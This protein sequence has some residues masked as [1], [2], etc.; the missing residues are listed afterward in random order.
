MNQD[1]VELYKAFLKLVEGNSK[2]WDQLCLE[3]S[4]SNWAIIGVIAI[5][6]ISIII[7]A[8]IIARLNKKE[9]DYPEITSMCIV[10]PLIITLFLLSI[11]GKLV[12]DAVSPS[13]QLTK[14]LLK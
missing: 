12:S 3:Y 9:H 14:E 2:Y 5:A 7:A 6:I 10:I 13:I 4:N 1:K 8:I 11:S